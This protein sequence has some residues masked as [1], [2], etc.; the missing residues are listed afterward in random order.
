[1]AFHP[2]CHRGAWVSTHKLGN[3]KLRRAVG[4]HGGEHQERRRR[5][6][7]SRVCWRQAGAGEAR[8]PL[9]D[10]GSNNKPQGSGEG[11]RQKHAERPPLWWQWHRC[12]RNPRKS[13]QHCCVLSSSDHCGGA[14]C[15]GTCRGDG[16]KILKLLQWPTRLALQARLPG[17]QK[18]CVHA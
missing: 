14:E 11:Q 9:R 10:L 2:H 16:V 3:L 1:M 15:G 13:A 8:G 6:R 12:S 4:C 18:A 5:P 7:Y 17:W